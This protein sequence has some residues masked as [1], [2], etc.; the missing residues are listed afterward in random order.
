[1]KLSPAMTNC[2]YCSE[3]GVI[4][5][6]RTVAVSEG[7]G[8]GVS[9]SPCGSRHDVLTRLSRSRV[10]LSRTNDGG[11]YNRLV[12]HRAVQSGGRGQVPNAP[13]HC[14]GHDEVSRAELPAC[15][16]SYNR[17]DH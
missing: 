4:N 5:V 8:K 2:R 14:R 15:S 13:P 6:G 12:D 1:M 9:E 3:Y 16:L 10:L 11:F 7:E 17:I